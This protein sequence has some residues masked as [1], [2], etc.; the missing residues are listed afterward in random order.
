M[1]SAV[2]HRVESPTSILVYMQCPRK[3]Y[4]RYVKRLEQKPSIHLIVGNVVH[5]TIASFHNAD[6]SSMP[7]ERLFEIL[8]EQMIEEFRIRWGENSEELKSLGLDAKD[9]RAFYDE[10]KMMLDNF[11][12]YHINR[13]VA[14]QYRQNASLVEAF[15]RLKPK[16]ETKI[17]SEKYGIMGVVDA[18][19]DIDGKI[20]IIDYKTSKKTE[21]ND[22]CMIQLA[23]YALLYKESFGRTPDFVGIHFLRQGEK[24][25]RVTPDLLA[26]GEESCRSMQ[27]LARNEDVTIFPQRFSGLC[28]YRT[29]QCDF[30]ETCKPWN[31]VEFG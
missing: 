30:Y 18:I 10:T 23:L 25:M 12:Q 26:L 19:H 29:G 24:M 31:S 14:C 3:Y 11:F 28:K 7:V 5:S 16:T 13:V 8:H 21:I 27:A 22:E 15:K 20:V 4:Y 17:I 9:E 2:K 1:S 6:I